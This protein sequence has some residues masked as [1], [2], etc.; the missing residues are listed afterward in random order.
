MVLGRLLVN[1]S[2]EGTYPQGGEKLL[3]TRNA[4]VFTGCHLCQDARQVEALFRVLVLA[5]R[6]RHWQS[7]NCACH[8]RDTM[9]MRLGC[10][11]DDAC[12]THALV[13]CG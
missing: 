6:L 8:F 7:V 9:A 13:S 12:R 4:A 5:R 3:S 11:L 2:L 10:S 1:M